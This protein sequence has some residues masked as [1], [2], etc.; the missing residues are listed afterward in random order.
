MG[1]DASWIY[2]TGV[3]GCLLVILCCWAHMG[4]ALLPD[5]GVVVDPHDIKISRTEQGIELIEFPPLNNTYI[6][7]QYACRECLQTTQETTRAG[8]CHGMRRVDS[9]EKNK[10]ASATAAAAVENA[11]GMRL[12]KSVPV[13]LS[14]GP[15]TF[16]HGID[17]DI[18][19]EERGT[20]ILSADLQHRVWRLRLRSPTALSL[21]LLFDRFYLPHGAHLH[22]RNDRASL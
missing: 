12:P 6:R 20:W 18:D 13:G 3:V 5:I 4:A 15:L 17:V 10:G 22:I 11:K 19:I 14:N 9:M 1:K 8:E 7:E 2:R 16:G 21:N